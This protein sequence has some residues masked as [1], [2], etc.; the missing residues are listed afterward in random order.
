MVKS[1]VRTK[2]LLDD[3]LSG[4]DLLVLAIASRDP[5]KRVDLR[6]EV[7]YIANMHGDEVRTHESDG[8]ECF[9]LQTV[10]HELLL[11]FA[12]FLLGEYQSN[13]RVRWLLNNTR[14]HLMPTM[15]PDGYAT[16]LTRVGNNAACRGA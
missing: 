5:D 7:L 3:F 10:G 6:P 4:T 1:T 12:E 14:V 11:H 16:T 8:K 15:N 2:C 13:V 9:W